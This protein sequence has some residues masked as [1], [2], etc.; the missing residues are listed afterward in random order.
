MQRTLWLI[1]LEFFLC[2]KVRK[3][4]PVFF[5]PRVTGIMKENLQTNKSYK[6]LSKLWNGIFIFNTALYVV[7]DIRLL[8]AANNDLYW[9]LCLRPHIHFLEVKQ[10]SLSDCRHA[11]F[12]FFFF[13]P[14]SGKNPFWLLFSNKQTGL[15]I[16]HACKHSLHTNI[17]IEL[18][19]PIVTQQIKHTGNLTRKDGGAH[20]VRSRSFCGNQQR[21]LPRINRNNNFHYQTQLL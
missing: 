17:G 11:G 15:I 8:S 9:V 12:H 16:P 21:I 19:R 18:H 5:S 3:N 4:K 14:V 7:V 2:I 13:F 1:A 20:W 6:V 10:L